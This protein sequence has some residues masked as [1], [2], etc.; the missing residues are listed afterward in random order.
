MAMTW[1]SRLA[2]VK[3]DTFA[4]YLASR[5]PRVGWPAKLLGAF[6][7]AYALSPLDLIPDFIPVLGYLDDAILIPL[8]LVLFRKMIPP[9]VFEEHRAAATL[10][11]S[12]GIGSRVAA[13]TIIIIWVALAAL[14]AIVILR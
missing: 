6:V 7:L 4:L 1:R 2:E 11:L 10:R 8:G 5:D 3:R 13:A 12:G 14:A 9:G